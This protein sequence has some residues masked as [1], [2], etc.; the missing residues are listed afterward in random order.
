MLYFIAE[1]LIISVSEYCGESMTC[2]NSIGPVSDLKDSYFMLL[3]A[4]I[5]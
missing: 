5:M 1:A 3:S 4:A 2:F